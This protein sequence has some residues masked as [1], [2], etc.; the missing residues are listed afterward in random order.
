MHS[1]PEAFT[2]AFSYCINFEAPIVNTATLRNSAITTCWWCLFFHALHACIPILDEL[3]AFEWTYGQMQ[4]HLFPKR[5]ATDI[6]REDRGHGGEL[7][8]HG[9]AAT[10]EF[11]LWVCLSLL[12]VISF[13]DPLK[14]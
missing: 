7:Q 8:N 14:V 4:C 5:H 12:P 10:S 9:A 11:A 1:R 6:E 3:H 2:H 13:R